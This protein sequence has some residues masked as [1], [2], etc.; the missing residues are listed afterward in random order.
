[1]SEVAV[2]II[3]LTYNQEKYIRDALNG[4]LK[5]Q[6][7]FAYEILIHDDVSTDG[8]TAVL[9][10]YQERHPDRIRLI[11]EEENQY[12]KGIDITKDIVLPYVKGKYIAFCEGDDYW[13]CEKKLQKQ[14]ELMEENP[15][16]SACYHNALVY[17]EEKDKLTLNIKNQPSGY[18]S[19]K[20]AIGTGKG[21]YPTGSVFYRTEYMKDKPDFKAPTGD[22]ELR[23]YMA[24]RGKLYFINQAWSVYRQFSKGS[25]NSKYEVDK[26]LAQAY[27]RNLVNYLINFNEYSHG[28]FEQYFY[29]RLSRS[30]IYYI[31]THSAKQ[32]T[33]EEFQGYMEELKT[34][35]E[36]KADVLLD[37]IYAVEAIRCTDYYLVTVRQK[38]QRLV[39][40]NT[41]L[42]I[43]GAGTEALKALVMLQKYK[44]DVDGLVVSKRTMN[45]ELL[46][47]PIYEINEIQRDKKTVI[48]PCF[49][50]EREMVIR[51]LSETNDS[52]VIV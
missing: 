31:Q 39:T 47:Y 46:G 44:I 7:N 40:E 49:V 45:H 33:M 11:L 8:T 5:Q 38:I 35:T 13:I 25:W 16:I 4:F 27:I 17:E 29:E 26:E 6:T 48:W 52:V 32:Y 42:Y 3:C 30:L 28:Q 34:I 43:Y 12:S 22:E 19:D 10:E 50:K 9:K 51:L 37:Q 14:Y 23:N 2:S 20:D 36:H 41:R 21:W 24:C 1:M 15:E 18:I